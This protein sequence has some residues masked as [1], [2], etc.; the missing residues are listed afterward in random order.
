MAAGDTMF[1]G[2]TVT[3]ATVSATG[4]TVTAAT[5][6]ATGRTVMDSAMDSGLL[7]G[8]VMDAGLLLGMARG[9]TGLGVDFGQRKRK[10]GQK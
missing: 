2:A 6:S 7:L 10:S 3:A 5:V 4:R 8:T 9:V 1:L